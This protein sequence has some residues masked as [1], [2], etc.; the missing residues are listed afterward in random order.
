MFIQHMKNPPFRAKGNSLFDKFNI[1]TR[2]YDYTSSSNPK[3][4]NLYDKT[5]NLYE[6]ITDLENR[7]SST[8]KYQQSFME[9][10]Y[11]FYYMF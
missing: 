4:N 10:E 2:N 9:K 7:S 6:K 5:K 11:L 3:Y 1:F 8:P